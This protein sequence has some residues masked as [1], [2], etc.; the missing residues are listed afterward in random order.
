MIASVLEAV[1]EPLQA[2]WEQQVQ[3]Q[4]RSSH[5]HSEMQ[6]AWDQRSNLGGSRKKVVWH[7]PLA[8]PQAIPDVRDSN[9]GSVMPD[10][11]PHPTAAITRERLAWSGGDAGGQ[12]G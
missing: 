9:G 10:E 11:I 8:R 12:E 1:D 5:L 3:E 2:V 7:H 6:A 4:V